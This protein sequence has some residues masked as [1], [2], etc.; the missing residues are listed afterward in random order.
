MSVSVALAD[1]DQVIA[2]QTTQGVQFQEFDPSGDPIGATTS[3]TSANAQWLSLAQLSNGGFS[4]FWGASPNSALIAQDYTANGTACGSP[5]SPATPPPVAP[6]AFTS[7][8]TPVGGLNGSWTTLL[9]NGDTVTVTDSNGSAGTPPSLTTQLYDASG[10]PVG[11]AFVHSVQGL[12]GLGEVGVAPLANGNFA[13]GFADNQNYGG[14]VYVDLF[15]AAGSNLVSEQVATT[16]YQLIHD[17]AI[18]GVA[19]GGFVMTWVAS[20]YETQ[21]LNHPAP[22]G[23]YAEEFNAAG[24]PVDQAHLLTTLP[25][26]YTAPEIAAFANGQ[27][28][29]SWTAD[30]TAQ[31]ATFTDPGSPSSPPAS[32]TITTTAPTYAAP[33]GV[34]EIILAG[35]AAQTVTA[36]NAGDTIVSNDYLSTLIGGTGNDT[37]IAGHSANIMTGGGGDDTFVFNAIPWNNT[38]HITDFNTAADKLDLSGLFGS[39]GYTGSDPVADGTLSFVSDGHG[40]TLVEINTHDASNPWPAVITTLDGVS[41]S[42]ITPA[43]Y[44]FS[45]SGSTSSGGLSGG[46]TSSGGAS[47]GGT[48]IDTSAASY[49]APAGV[50]SIVLTGSAAQ[51]VTANNAGDTIT[52]NDY[53]STLIGGTGNDTLIAGTDANTLTGAGGYDTFVFNSL[54]WNNDGAIT[55]FN[56]ATDVLNLSGIFHQMGYTGTDPI[57]DGTLG[58]VSDGNGN[59]LVEIN[60]HNP[61]SP[62]PSIVTTLE[63][64]TP[65]ALHAGDWVT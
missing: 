4:V 15:G 12:P 52:S 54:P 34:H 31:S 11:A 47:S 10:N 6:V 63:H 3:V 9:P 29:V 24:S 26:D 49:V 58:F 22:L 39:I 59:T 5:Y 16:G 57:A 21:D 56:P 62:W 45:D 37:L 36:N 2:W 51:T 41:A 20:T 30:G 33:D 40:N 48:T 61:S 14:A 13:V 42:S 28:T 65:S 1:G 17:L 60:A 38:G 19:D 46:G 55:D 18:S 44:G 50:T 23:V 27:Y 53:Q 64:V 8:D 35:A 7:L 25:A 43:D 32:D